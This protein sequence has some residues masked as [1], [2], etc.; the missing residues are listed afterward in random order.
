[1]MEVYFMATPKE[2]WNAYKKSVDAVASDIG[3]TRAGQTV[4][5]SI[6]NS[7][8]SDVN[9]GATV[10]DLT[11]GARDTMMS[12]Y[13]EDSASSLNQA[14]KALSQLEQQG[15]SAWEIENQQTVVNSLQRQYDAM[16]G[17]GA[18]Q[19][20]ATQATY[21]LADD[22]KKS[23]EKSISMAKDGLGYIGKTAV[24]IGAKLTEIGI[25]K[26]KAFFLLGRWALILIWMKRSKSWR[27][28]SNWSRSLRA[29]MATTHKPHDKAVLI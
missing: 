4:S 18:V 28:L 17:A 19:R 8:A 11:Q 26:A 24:D 9:T 14:K 16:A 2:I 20:G 12:S 13:I 27:I 23:A 6:K 15:A 25:D 29:L 10:Y 7:L 21:Q 22:I 1:M 3:N 5:G